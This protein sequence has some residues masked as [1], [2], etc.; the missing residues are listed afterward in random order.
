MEKVGCN[1]EKL[2]HVK[3]AGSIAQKVNMLQTVKGIA[4]ERDKVDY[5]TIT[6]AVKYR[7]FYLPKFLSAPSLSIVVALATTH[8]SALQLKI[9]SA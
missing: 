7:H 6:P 2:F 3:K 4:P 9:Y 1:M 8:S 5:A